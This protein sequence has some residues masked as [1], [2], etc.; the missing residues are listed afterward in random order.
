MPSA[1]VK[2]LKYPKVARPDVPSVPYINIYATKFLWIIFVTVILL[3]KSHAVFHE[4]EDDVPCVCHLASV[5][6]LWQY[7]GYAKK[8][9]PDKCS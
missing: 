3:L 2:V 4:K 5:T 9:I 7:H 1:E 8:I 6:L